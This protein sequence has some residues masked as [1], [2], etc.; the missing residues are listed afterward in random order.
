MSTRPGQVVTDLDQSL[1]IFTGNGVLV[2][3]PLHRA[4]PGDSNEDQ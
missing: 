2:P 1:H 3:E 4:R